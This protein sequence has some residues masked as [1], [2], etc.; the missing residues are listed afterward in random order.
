MSCPRAVSM[1]PMAEGITFLPAIACQIL[2]GRARTARSDLASEARHH[3]CPQRQLDGVAERR[4]E[5]RGAGHGVLRTEPLPRPTPFQNA[6]STAPGSAASSVAVRPSVHNPKRTRSGSRT[7]LDNGYSRRE[8]RW[9]AA[10]S[11]AILPPTLHA[12]ARLRRQKPPAR[13]PQPTA[14]PDRPGRA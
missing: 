2:V 14:A 13:A 7:R 11:L 10:R 3:V 6:Q 1:P 4:M 12:R 8:S 9:G 5:K